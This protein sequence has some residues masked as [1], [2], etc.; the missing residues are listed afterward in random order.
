M[1]EFVVKLIKQTL[2]F[3]SN[4]ERILGFFAD[5]IYIESLVLIYRNQK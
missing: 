2:L 4:K 3:C 1:V 5:A